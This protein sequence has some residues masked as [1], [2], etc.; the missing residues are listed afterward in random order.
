MGRA[1]KWRVSVEVAEQEVCAARKLTKSGTAGPRK[2][3]RG[4]AESVTPIF[5]LAPC[6][7]G[8]KYPAAQNGVSI[9]S[10]MQRTPG[11]LA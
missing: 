2:D 10:L 3:F 11:P 7:D 8:Q 9:A 5:V 4:A 6:A 1:R